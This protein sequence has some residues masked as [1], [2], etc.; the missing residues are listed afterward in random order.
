[1]IYIVSKGKPAHFSDLFQIQIQSHQGSFKAKWTRRGNVRDPEAY[2]LSKVGF[3][4][5][6]SGDDKESR[7]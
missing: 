5:K 4:K 7:I 6:N 2:E 3:A 1:M